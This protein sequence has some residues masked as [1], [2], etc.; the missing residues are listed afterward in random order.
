[1]K[2]QG[3]TFLKPVRGNWI[4]SRI[5]FCLG[6]L[7]T[8]SVLWIVASV[9]EPDETLEAFTNLMVGCSALAVAIIAFFGLE[10]WKRLLKAVES[11][12]NA[13]R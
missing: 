12:L 3:F 4:L 9:L 5:L 2:N 7:A 6:I 11:F 10:T 8:L 13:P 1:M